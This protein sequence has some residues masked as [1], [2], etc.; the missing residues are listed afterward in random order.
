MN[1]TEMG[2]YEQ[3]GRYQAGYEAAIAAD[4]N[5]IRFRELPQA[6]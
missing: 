1:Y 4:R 2:R 5:F 3:D 6:Q